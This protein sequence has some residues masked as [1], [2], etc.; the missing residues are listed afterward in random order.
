MVADVPGNDPARDLS[1]ISWLADSPLFIDAQQI[2]AFY[3]AVVGPAFRTVQL[4]FSADKN[5]ETEKAAGARLGA[6]LA[7]LFGWLS[8]DSD[9][10]ARRATRKGRREGRGVVL[11]PIQSATRQLVEL[12]LHY[13]ASQPDRICYVGQGS[14]LPGPDVIAASPRM[15]AF[16]DASPGTMFLPQAAE[17]DDGRAETFFEPLAEKLNPAGGTMPAPY[18]QNTATGGRPTSAR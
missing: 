5:E 9:I 15:V 3:D 1:S 18:P 2:S 14:P 10:E 8:V 16:V 11:E 7:P 6:K 12:S 13:L 4:Q 17:L